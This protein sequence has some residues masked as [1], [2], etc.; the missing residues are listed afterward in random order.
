MGPSV[1]ERLICLK[2]WFDAAERVQYNNAPT[3]DSGFETQSVG[4][5][6]NDDS[7]I[8]CDPREET[9]HWYMYPNNY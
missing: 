2:D 5:E 6:A 4:T 7:D 8:E 9:G 1:F 3:D